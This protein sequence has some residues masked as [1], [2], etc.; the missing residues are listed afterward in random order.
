MSAISPTDLLPENVSPLPG[1]AGCR[2]VDAV[3]G[4]TPPYPYFF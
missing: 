3:A 4:Q 1:P 2:D